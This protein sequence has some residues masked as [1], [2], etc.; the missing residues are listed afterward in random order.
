MEVIDI[1]HKRRSIRKFNGKAISNEDLKTILSAGM[2]SPSAMNKQ[3]WQFV[4][5][6]DDKVKQ[7]IVKISVYAQMVTQSPLS[8]LVCGD[9]KNCF[10]DYWKIDCSACIQ[11]MLLAACSLNIGSV[12]TGV[13]DKMSAQYKQ[14]FNLPENIEPHSLIVF[15]YSDIPFEKRDYY[16]ESKIHLNKW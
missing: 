2:T 15:G 4:V 11:N 14:L 10:L 16:N 12:W 6:D 1:I 9:T 13:D 8:I 5:I 7:E 3:P